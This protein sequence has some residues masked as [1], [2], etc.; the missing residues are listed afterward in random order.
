[1]ARETFEI[2]VSERGSRE[3]TRNIRN[4]GS[5]STSVVKDVNLLRNALGA[6]FTLGAIKGIRRLADEFTE[7]QNRIRLV[8]SSTEQ[9]NAVQQELFSLS[10]RTRT[11][12][13]EN[14]RL[15]YRL[16]V[17]TG[18]LNLS[19]KEL[20]G[21]TETVAQATIVAGANAR[22][23]SNGV[24]QFSQAMAAGVLSGQALKSVVEFMPR[25][26]KAIGKEFGVAEKSLIA[27]A[28]ANPGI[29]T[30]ERIIKAIRDEAPLIAAEFEKVTPTVQ[31]SFTVLRT[32][33]TR[34]VGGLGQSIGLGRLFADAV[35]L[36]TDN[37][38]NLAIVLGTIA[39]IGAFNIL[40]STVL[41]FGSTLSGVL[42]F[43]TRGFVQLGAAIAMVSAAPFRAAAG[44]ITLMT[45]ALRIAV[46]STQALVSAMSVLS[47]L[48]S[49]GGALYLLQQGFLALRAATIAFG[50][51][52]LVSFAP[53]VA[54][55]AIIGGLIALI[56]TFRREIGTWA[57]EWISSTKEILNKGLRPLAAFSKTLIDQW[58]LVV[59][60][61]KDIMIRSANAV[62][63]ATVGMINGVR[64]NV[65]GWINW[66]A[67]RQVIEIKDIINVDE[68]KLINTAEGAAA[69]FGEAFNNNLQ[70]VA[71]KDIISDIVDSGI[72]KFGELKDYLKSFRTENIMG[73][74]LQ[75]M[76]DQVPD[77]MTG[78]TDVVGKKSRRYS[79]EDV[80]RELEGQISLIGKEGI[81]RE[82][83]QKVLQFEKRLKADL[84]GAQ[85]EYVM[86]MLDVIEKSKI[87]KEI[88]DEIN[89]AT[90]K[91]I[92]GTEA[93]DALMARG[94]ITTDQYSKK[95]REL[96]IESLSF[97]DA[98][99][100]GIE[101]G[102]LRIEGEIANSAGRVENIMT[103]AYQKYVQPQLNLRDG[104]AGLDELMKRQI[105]TVEQ[106]NDA[107]RDLRIEALAVGKDLESGVRR[108]LLEISKQFENVADLAANTLVNAF[109]SAEDALVE[110]VTTGKTDIKGLVDSIFVELTRLAI[111]QSIVAP[112][113]S[114][115]QGK[116]GQ[117]G[118][119]AGVLNGMFSRGS[120]SDWITS[121]TS[122]LGGMFSK[123]FS[124]LPGFKTGADFM[125]GGTGGPDSQVVAFRASPDERVTVTPKGKGGAGG[126]TINMYIQAQDAN[127]FQRSQGQ[128]LAKMQA[129]LDRA[130]RRNN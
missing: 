57:S 49:R 37:L 80:K 38:E 33:L 40:T 20:L 113:A 84:T 97:S 108:G 85:R 35:K 1:M 116:D 61:L 21:I 126:G 24:I 25:V 10:I 119:L 112:I 30:T 17:S 14:A 86:T 90:L 53:L 70:D 68:R 82:K 3:V 5:T 62:I 34:F 7:V 58:E 96:K 103:S 73:A 22:E 11:G 32:E 44:G 45:A 74:E 75:K 66:A 4:I 118:A 87:Q 54:K 107:L 130:N 29:L 28:R 88:Y 42:V 93:L 48:A 27:F 111:R 129:G 123:L 91:L 94:A 83:L 92:Q 95:L 16:A 121:A 43:A 114:L 98:L 117:G 8:T 47:L 101:R 52:L 78:T 51:A 23:A 46:T 56:V 18:D 13:S 26:A 122:G 81:E 12:V 128:I 115:F 36:I 77:I 76:L 102:M 72:E 109:K 124:F 106:Y 63:E 127:S 67:G 59:P 110:F 6:A 31:Q 39:V 104:M 19:Y 100:D 120:G 9:L 71:G 60:A 79:F 2:I 15:F 89:G 65:A 64:N 125:V 55:A 99:A 50:R 69:A 41:A 105:I